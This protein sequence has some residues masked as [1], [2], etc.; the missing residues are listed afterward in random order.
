MLLVLSAGVSFRAAGKVFV[1]LKICLELDFGQ[2]SHTAI[3]NWTKKQG[4][5][6]FREREYFKGRKW[7]LIADE[8]IQ[9]GN[10]KLLFV[11]AIPVD[12]DSYGRYLIYSDLTPVVIQVSSSWKSEQIAE[13]IKKSIFPED[14]VYAV[15]DNGSNLTCAF[16]S[17][18]IIHIEDINHKFSNIMQKLFEQDET[19]K[20]YTKCLSD[21][22]AGLSMSQYAR[23]VPPNQRIMSRYMNLTPL[24]EWGIKMIKLLDTNNL[25]KEEKEILSF[26][27]QYRTFVFETGKML[28][29]LNTIQKRVK[30]EG[31]S[32]SSIKESLQLFENEKNTNLD[33]VKCQVIEYFHNML[34]RVKD[35]ERLIC[36]SD[37]VES[38][39]SKYKE[40]VKN[41]KTVGISD[42]SL[43][44]SAIL[45]E[46]TDIK[47]CFERISVKDVQNWKKEN[48]GETLFGQKRKLLKNI[49]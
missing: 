2:P 34:N 21:M 30:T 10:K 32:G 33:K 7:V 11:T 36:S 46:C 39:F 38:C 12:A 22:R 49:A 43:C 48:I 9:F 28:L 44:I 41:N 23:I 19:F 3:L 16:K 37:I 29:I 20:S 4:I 18:N 40:L 1:M 31:L 24:F 42:L 5:G 15:S 27:Y 47:E 35:R 17:L 8:S 26:L 13:V 14:V 45:G 6:N 25:S